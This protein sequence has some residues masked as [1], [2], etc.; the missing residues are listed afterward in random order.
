MTRLAPFAAAL[1]TG[2]LLFLAM[3]FPNLG[4]LSFVAFLPLFW[5]LENTPNPRRSF[6]AGWFG[7]S[8]FFLLLLYWL[9]IPVWD[10]GGAYRHL[11]VFGLFILFMCRYL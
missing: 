1:G 3:A 5:M 6:F 11:G 7:G 2:L 10:F 8:V 4:F 9:A